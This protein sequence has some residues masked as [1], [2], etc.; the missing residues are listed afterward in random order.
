MDQRPRGSHS[1]T[2]TQGG[3]LL[4]LN[5][6]PFRL[7]GGQVGVL[8]VH[9]FSGRAAEMRP[10]ADALHAAGYTVA[11]PALAGHGDDFPEGLQD[12]AWRAW[13]GDVERAFD[14]LHARAPLVFVVGQSMGGTLATL[15]A[16]SRP[17]AGLVTLGTP[18]QIASWIPAAAAIGGR[19]MP[20][21]YPFG[22]ANMDDPH[23]QAQVQSLLPGVDLGDPTTRAALKKEIRF[24]FSAIATLGDLF[25]QARRTAPYVATPAL[26]LQGRQDQ[27]TRE[28]DAYLLFGLLGSADKH[29]I[30]FEQSGHLLLEGP[31]RQA[32][33][34]TVL[35]WIGERAAGL[36][37]LPRGREEV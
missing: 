15:L 31:E 16:Q 26:T 36:A 4:K 37:P 7:D 10:L 19:L 17:L 18:L 35:S 29:L 9:G 21:F 2:H 6:A 28:V 23:V 24:P 13:L 3:F 32:V 22:L 11:A 25:G 33:I 1:A 5:R 34:T 30:W 20:W 8:L 12:L 14:D 27:V